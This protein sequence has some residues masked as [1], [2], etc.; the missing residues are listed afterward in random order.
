MACAILCSTAIKS[1]ISEVRSM[2]WFGSHRKNSSKNQA[3]S[4]THPKKQNRKRKTFIL[5]VI[6]SSIDAALCNIPVSKPESTAPSNEPAKK[7]SCR[8]KV[9]SK[10]AKSCSDALASS[11]YL[12]KPCY[13][14][15]INL[16]TSSILC[17]PPTSATALACDPLVTLSA[18]KGLSR[19]A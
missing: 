17:C 3:Q 5:E 13:N 16:I 14:Y 15:R 4:K 8:I 11:A 9:V 1:L 6:S 10:Q 2:G 7:R 12:R 19:N 18:K